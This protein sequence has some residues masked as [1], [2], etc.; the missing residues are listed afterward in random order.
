MGN[1][2]KC[3]FV[4]PQ[5]GRRV[6][7]V[8]GR[9]EKSWR[10][11]ALETYVQLQYFSN[12]SA[13]SREFRE[14]PWTSR[15]SVYLHSSCFSSLGVLVANLLYFIGSFSSCSRPQICAKP[16]GSVFLLVVLC[17]RVHK[18]THSAQYK[19]LKP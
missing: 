19:L 9:C 17:G 4:H 15:N 12:D 14:I 16:K 5:K 8:A 2:S 13:S 18:K 11:G 7:G 3:A 1:A 6:S 10:G